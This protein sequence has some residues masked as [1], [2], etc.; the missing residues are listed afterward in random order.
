MNV[1]QR[2]TY[3][4]ELPGNP[5]VFGFVVQPTKEEL[6]DAATYEYS[7]GPDHGDILVE[8]QPVCEGENDTRYWH[9]PD[10]LQELP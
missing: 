3:E 5:E 1:G 6:T 10:E 4:D 2:V 7:V 9:R 8:W